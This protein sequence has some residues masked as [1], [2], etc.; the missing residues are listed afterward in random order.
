MSEN[1]IALSQD[2]VDKI[3][4]GSSVQPPKRSN[5]ETEAKIKMIKE[6]TKAVAK[7]MKTT[8]KASVSKKSSTA[9]KASASKKADSKKKVTKLSVY[10]EGKLYGTGCVSSKNGKKIIELLTVRK[11]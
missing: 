9:K 4:K 7:K 3:L 8:A 5:E 1:N 6:K 11:K 2:E 10:F